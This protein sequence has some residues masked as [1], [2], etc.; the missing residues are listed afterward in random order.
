MLL[1]DRTALI[2]GGARGIGRGIALKFA[3][4]GCAVAIADIREEEGQQTAKEIQGKGVKSIFIK[5]DTTNE[6]QVI[7][8]AKKVV[9]EFGKIDILVNNAGG[10]GKTQ[11]LTGV[12]EDAWDKML[13]GITTYQEVVRVTGEESSE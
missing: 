12:T 3:E 5:C 7:E 13:Q 10:F 4:E 11:F 6:A 2:T 8:M 1:K 9:T